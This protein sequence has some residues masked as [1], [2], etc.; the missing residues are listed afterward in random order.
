MT[1][2]LLHTLVIFITYSNADFK[3]KL[4]KTKFWQKLYSKYFELY[5]LRRSCNR[6][7]IRTTKKMVDMLDAIV[8]PPVRESK[9]SFNDSNKGCPSLYSLVKSNFFFS[10]ACLCVCW[11]KELHRYNINLQVK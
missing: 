2:T 5:S 11:F 4:V 1:P 3:L 9:K 10:L 6:N 7:V 8:I